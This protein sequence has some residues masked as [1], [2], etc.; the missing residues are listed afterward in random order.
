MNKVLKEKELQE[1]L[2]R[3]PVGTPEPVRIATVIEVLSGANRTDVAK[4]YGVD[5]TSISRWKRI[6]ASRKEI[7]EEMAMRKRT[8][9]QA[10]LSMGIGKEARMR[11]LVELKKEVMEKE[12]EI[13]FLRQRLDLSE[14]MI[15]AAEK[16]YHIEIKKKLGSRQ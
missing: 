2:H 5:P 8:S 12:R 11:K 9:K 10:V 14:T 16:L 15:D 3:G 4:K 7:K 13:K 6:F 1:H